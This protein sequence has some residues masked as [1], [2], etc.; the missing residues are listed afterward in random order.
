MRC[1]QE[2]ET[3]GRGFS[4]RASLMPSSP[5]GPGQT[6]D[7]QNCERAHLSVSKPLGSGLCDS[8]PCK[9]FAGSAGLWVSRQQVHVQHAAREG[10]NRETRLRSL[11]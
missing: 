6:S 7:P 5:G 9:L 11:R 10:K 8:S 3:Q 1:L 2:L 4:L